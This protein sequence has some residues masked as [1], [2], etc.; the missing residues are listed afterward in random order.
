[1]ETLIEKDLESLAA[2][3]EPLWAVPIE[4]FPDYTLADKLVEYECAANQLKP[5]I[6]DM[7]E[8]G[9]LNGV[10]TLEVTH[11]L[12]LYKQVVRVSLQ[13]TRRFTDGIGR[14]GKSYERIECMHF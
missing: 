10:Q 6:E 1:M 9:F 13:L 2:R 11:H 4:K 3:I 8:D 7:E 12:F 5:L 14:D